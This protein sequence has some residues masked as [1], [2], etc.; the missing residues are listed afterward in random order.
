MQHNTPPKAAEIS[1]II[2]KRLD[3]LGSK[4]DAEET[5]SIEWRGST[6]SI[7]V[8]SM[9]VDLLAYNP[10]THR[11][12]AQLSMDE[13]GAKALER[14]PWGD[15]AQGYLHRLL[16]GDP[17]DP[18]KPDPSFIALQEDLKEYGQNEPGIVTRDGVLINGN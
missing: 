8:L 1:A 10:D 15:E 12:R 2:A 17:A 5:V 16:M 14:D 13:G 7:P 3:E 4:K 11:I 18:S 6:I 9:E